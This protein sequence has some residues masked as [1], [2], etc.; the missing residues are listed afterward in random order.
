MVRRPRLEELI[1]SLLPCI[2]L[3]ERGN[4]CVLLRYPGPGQAEVLFPE[5]GQ[6]QVIDV[7]TL[8]RDYAGLAILVRPQFRFD[9]RIPDVRLGESRGWFWGTLLRFWPIYGH[10]LIASVLI[11]MFAVAMPLFIMNV[12]DRVVPNRAIE[13]LWALAIGVLI[14]FGFDFLLRN[15][16][17]YFVDTAGKNADVMISS[18][19][20]GQQLSVR[21]DKRDQSTGSMANNIREFE[22]LREFFTSG[23]VVALVD[24]PFIFLFIGVIHFIAGPLAVIPLVAVPLVIL[25]GFVLQHPLRR[26][27]ERSYRESAQKHAILVEA[28]DGLETIKTSAAEGVVQR[29]WE[30]C[31]G[32]TADTSKKARVFSTLS[33]SFAQTTVQLCTVGVVIFGVYRIAEGELTMGALVAATILTGR[34]LAPLGAVAAMLTRLQQSRVALKGLDRLMKTD[35]ERPS[36]RAFLH[37][38]H[39]D[40][41]IALDKVCFAYPGQAANALDNVSFRVRPGEKIGVLGRIGSGKSTLAR[42]L[43]GLYEPQSGSV[44]ID[45]I[46]IRQFDPADLRHNVGYVAQDNFLFYG[47]IRDNIC[48]SAPFAETRAMERAA[49]I[50]GIA[51]FV[52][53]WPD[54]Y[55]QQVGER[56]M[57]LSG[58]QRQAVAIARTLLI[59]PPV[60]VL[61]EPTSHM[62]NA[63]E[64]KF[65]DRLHEALGDKT[66]VLATHRSSMLSLVERIVVLDNGKV[67]AD[68]P[69]DKVLD[70]LRR[71]GIKTSR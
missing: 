17:S 57:R 34:S 49:H 25:F 52:R 20:L 38:P 71:G 63:S 36:E 21:M 65:R 22:S 32:A 46:D 68:G 53:S 31:V 42:L 66:L 8:Q 35:T 61:D 9:G 50:A 51:D 48:F 70:A 44:L 5:G 39:V 14:V 62:D 27:M 60:L 55:D 40:G 19:L 24:L 11:N 4:A 10:V 16:R 37:R 12:Y 23:T 59:D 2:L 30:R 26:L 1:A 56:G 7:E 45:D 29:T 67:V 28:I 3:L 33:T 43:V 13:T 15:L 47:S 54:G 18:N 58:G 69:K 41:R 64:A 6:S